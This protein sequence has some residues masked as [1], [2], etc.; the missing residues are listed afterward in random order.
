MYFLLFIA[1]ILIVRIETII[2]YFR[3]NDLGWKAN[4]KNYKEI[5]YSERI[6]GKWQHIKVDADITIGTFEPKFKS[7]SE[8]LSYP[9]WAQDREKIIER[10]QKRYPIKDEVN[11]IGTKNN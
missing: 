7:K 3:D 1:F 5:T 6:D 11:D 9:E 10:V 8:W 2:T 4:K